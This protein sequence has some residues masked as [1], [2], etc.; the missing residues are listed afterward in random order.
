MHVKIQ[1]RNRNM[2]GHAMN[3]GASLTNLLGKGICRLDPI[4]WGQGWV[5]VMRKSKSNGSAT[6]GS[7]AGNGLFRFRFDPEKHPKIQGFGCYLQFLLPCIILVSLL[8]GHKFFHCF[9]DTFHWCSSNF[10]LVASFP[11][12]HWAQF[13]LP[14]ERQMWELFLLPLCRRWGAAC[15]AANLRSGW[16]LY[17][18]GP[19]LLH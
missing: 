6:A 5:F 10:Q 19:R 13:L 12:P 2:T 1:D 17:I 18:N 3:L 8:Q 14:M 11:K 9:G 16:K 4:K 7:G 15:R